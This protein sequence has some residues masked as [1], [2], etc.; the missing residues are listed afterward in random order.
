MSI[1]NEWLQKY[2]N[3][4]S[5]EY[6]PSQKDYVDPV[7][8]KDYRRYNDAQFNSEKMKIVQ[9]AKNE[10]SGVYMIRNVED[11]KIYVGS[12]GD[13]HCRWAVHKFELNCGRHY[14]RHLQGDFDRLGCTK[15]AFEIIWQ[16]P[17]ES[18]RNEIYEMEQFYIDKYIPEYN[19]ETKVSLK[20]KNY[21]PSQV[22]K[23]KAARFKEWIKK[24]EEEK[25]IFREQNLNRSAIR[26]VL[27]FC[28]RHLAL[29]VYKL[30]NDTFKVGKNGTSAMINQ[31]EFSVNGNIIQ[32]K[33]SKPM[34]I[35]LA[36]IFGYEL[37]FSQYGQV[38]A[39]KKQS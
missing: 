8:T 37:E 14:N 32:P 27:G 2:L 15:F 38:T 3:D 35:E 10:C 4:L 24:K 9:S 17:K 26:H 33:K 12:A 18:D 25:R 20:K 6:N 39:T 19:I 34:M 31:K 23:E 30:P 36:A 21:N 1:N 29:N 7:K 16:A 11:D 28:A 22:A 13:I 5:E